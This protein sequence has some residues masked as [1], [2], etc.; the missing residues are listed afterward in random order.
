MDLDREIDHV[1]AK[2][3]ANE[4]NPKE[5]LA[6]FAKA[7]RSEDTV[8]V[9]RLTPKC[10]SCGT[11]D[12]VCF[13]CKALELVGEKGMAAMPLLL[14]RLA[15]LVGQWAA[16]RRAKRAAQA[17]EAAHAQAQAQAAAQAASRKPPPPPAGPQK[18]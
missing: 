15:G 13:R 6:N 17:Q 18:F 7:V 11:P 5:V 2:L 4:G 12:A 8:T 3:M 1:L 16:E 14:P 10:A 9:E